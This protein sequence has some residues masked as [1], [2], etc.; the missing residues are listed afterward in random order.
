MAVKMNIYPILDY[1]PDSPEIIKPNHSIEDLR[2][3]EKCVY[4]FLGDIIDTFA[5][6]H[7]ALRVETLGSCL[8]SVG[9]TR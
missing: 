1:D 8:H 9:D 3:P 4:P 2:L 6:S 5:S 7:N